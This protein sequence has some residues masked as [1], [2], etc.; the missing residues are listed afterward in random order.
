MNFVK[1][2]AASLLISASAQ[3]GIKEKPKLP[4]TPLNI[5]L[6]VSGTVVLRGE[7]NASSVS[8]VIKAIENTNDDIVYLYLLTPGGSVFD[9]MKLVSYIRATPKKIVCIV[10]AAISMGFVIL[11]NCD[12]RVA[13]E[14]SLAMQHVSSYGLRPQ[15]APNAESFAAF[16]AR[17]I[18][19]IDKV[20][21]KRIGLS[22]SD[23][24]A[25]TRSDWW[26]YGQDV[27][28][29][30][31]V[32]RLATVTCTKKAMNAEIEETLSTPFGPVKINWSAC[33]IISAPLK[34]EMSRFHGGAK[35]EYDFIKALDIKTALGDVIP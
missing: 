3:A 34:V 25:K 1:I 22:Y 11:Q 21:A 19:I 9:G 7:V 12:E 32:D 28:D 27:V 6:D 18:E 13:T 17:S 8:S 23:F 4:K 16:L 33:P 35:E 24:K 14:S 26:T 10:D 2:I 29:N 20:Q 15:P 30:R 31:V 5:E